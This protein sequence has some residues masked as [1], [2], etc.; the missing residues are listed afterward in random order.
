[1]SNGSATAA[2]S[3]ATAAQSIANAVKASGAIVKVEPRDFISILDRISA[4][5]V[6]HAAGSLFTPR[7]QYL[8]GYKG[9]VFYTKSKEPLRFPADA[10]I[11]SAKKIW[12]PG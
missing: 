4:P 9:L 7:N 10:E 2:T 6:V 12:I 3:G 11:I 1:M 8:A 5:L